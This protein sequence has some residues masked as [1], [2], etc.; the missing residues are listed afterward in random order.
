MAHMRKYLAE[1]SVACR[2]SNYA[3]SFHSDNTSIIC[4]II[5]GFPSRL[6]FRTSRSV[7]YVVVRFLHVVF[8]RMWC[9]C[10]YMCRVTCIVQYSIVSY[11]ASSNLHPICMY[12][13]LCSRNTYFCI[14]FCLL[15][16]TLFFCFIS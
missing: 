8:I 4:S 9:V 15:K 5:G 6:L 12:L 3:T 11:L 13:F 1:I 2:S 7:T 10:V 14:Q 16:A